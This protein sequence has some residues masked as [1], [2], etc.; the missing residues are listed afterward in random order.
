MPSGKTQDWEQAYLRSAE[1][2]S[3]AGLADAILRDVSRVRPLPPNARVFEVGVG[4]GWLLIDLVERGFTC[5]GIELNPIFREHALAA[6]K[7]RGLR[8]EILSGSIESTPL[9]ANAYDVVLASSVFEHVPD[10]RSGLQ[11][12]YQAV[13]QGG[14][15]RLNT[16]NKFS[17]VSGEFAHFPLY[18]WLPRRLRFLIRTIAADRT[19]A[20]GPGFDWNQFT[21]RRLRRELSRVGFTEIH[22]RFELLRPEDTSGWKRELI[23]GYNRWPALK[24]PLLVFDFGTAFCCVK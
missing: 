11:N 24:L 20:S 2:Q 1:A 17:P 14:V 15:F 5:A 8:A 6:L 13:K 21:Y 3:H 19:I 22:D 12:V 4:A 18:G 23:R 10:Y 7:S 9:P 16:T